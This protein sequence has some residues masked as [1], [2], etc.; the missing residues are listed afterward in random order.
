MQTLMHYNDI[1]GGLICSLPDGAEVMNL[2]KGLDAGTAHAISMAIQV[3][4]RRGY[5]SGCENMS[6]AVISTLNAVTDGALM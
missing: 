3:A 4:Y 1:N 2:A 6:H 5:K